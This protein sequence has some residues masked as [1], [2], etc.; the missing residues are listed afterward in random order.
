MSYEITVGI[1]RERYHDLLREAEDHRLAR[2]ARAG[3]PG[4]ISRLIGWMRRGERQAE[5]AEWQGAQPRPSAS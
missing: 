2:R 4:V 1:A 5:P 3:R